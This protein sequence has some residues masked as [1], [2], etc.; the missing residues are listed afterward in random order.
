MLILNSASSLGIGTKMPIE[1]IVEHTGFCDSSYFCKLFKRNEG[2]T[3]ASFRK[4]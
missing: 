1:E 3:P 2:I 4:Y